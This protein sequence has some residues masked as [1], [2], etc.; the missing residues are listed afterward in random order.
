MRRR[1]VVTGLGTVNPLGAG[2]ENFWRAC[3]RGTSGVRTVDEFT[4]PATMS[5]VAGVVDLDW[6]G[7]RPLAADLADPHGLDRS[8]RLA[9]TA[10]REAMANAGLSTDELVALRP[11]RAGVS[12]ST[13]IAG[14]TKMEACFVADTDGGTRPLRPATRRGPGGEAFLFD[15]TSALVAKA[16]DL[17]GEHVTVATGCTGGVDAVAQAVGA[18]RRGEVDLVVAGASEAPITPLVVGSFAKIN[19]TS[20]RNDDPQG[21]S[22]PWSRGRDGFVLAEGSGMLVLESLEHAQA[23]DATIMAEISGTGSVNNYFHMTSMPADGLPIAR[24]VRLALE[25][26]LLG[27]DDID[28]INAHGSSTPMNDQAESNAFRAVFGERAGD[29][30]CTSI[31]SQTGHALS[32]ANAIELVASVLT[33]QHRRMPPTLNHDDPDP[34]CGLHIVRQ[35]HE[36]PQARHLL[37][38]SSGFAGIHSSLVLSRH[39]GVPA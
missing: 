29:I 22:R 39:E 25:D 4:I 19:A 3:L 1:V 14:I 9:V 10:A 21:A 26:A 6:D 8:V 23:R 38:T 33:L 5:R 11:D 34:G 27:A 18:I 13:A 12:I 32:A 24:S 15:T 16:L 36:V 31:K 17:P 7:G 35:A 37:K 20:L 28:C 2:V 30:P